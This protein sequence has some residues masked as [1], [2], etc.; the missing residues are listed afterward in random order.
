MSVQNKFSDN[1]SSLGELTTYNV[2][3]I[4]A[5]AHRALRQHKDSLLKN[6]GLTGVE[7]Y[8]IGT[9]AD[10]GST[11]IRTTDLA[12]ILGTTLGFL[13]KTVALLEA[14]KFIFKKANAEDAR[15]SFICFNE[16]K[17]AVLEEIEVAL[18]HKLRESI[19]GK[20]SPEELLTY[21][22][23]LQKFSQIK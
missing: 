5:S 20:V 4:E 7:W 2:G 18:R 19:Y 12:N 13:T 21:I 8:I 10:A 3:V 23:V 15:S 9:V 14:K 11:G 22:S 6:Y 16:K 1:L 17:R